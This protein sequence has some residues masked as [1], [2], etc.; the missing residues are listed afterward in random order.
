M[1]DV[2][3]SRL[4]AYWQDYYFDHPN[5]VARPW[6]DHPFTPIPSCMG[7]IEDAAEAERMKKSSC[8]WSEIVSLKSKFTC[9]E[10]IE[11]LNMWTQNGFYSWAAKKKDQPTKRVDLAKALA[12]ARSDAKSEGAFDEG[13]DA[14]TPAP[15]SAKITWTVHRICSQ[16][17]REFAKLRRFEPSALRSTAPESQPETEGADSAAV[18]ADSAAVQAASPDGHGTPRGRPS[19][20]SSCA[21]FDL[22]PPG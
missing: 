15:A 1:M 5:T 16:Q 7:D 11:E 13:L 17:P 3:E 2:A 12:K 19:V 22:T 9:A 6:K 20:A 18:Q 8:D 14:A 4:L 10:M 21:S